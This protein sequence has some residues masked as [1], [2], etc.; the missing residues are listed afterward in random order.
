MMIRMRRTQQ[1]ATFPSHVQNGGRPKYFWNTKKSHFVTDQSQLFSSGRIFCDGN[2]WPP[3]RVHPLRPFISP[4]CIRPPSFRQHF[5]H[6]SI[7][8]PSSSDTDA[9]K[10]YITVIRATWKP[11]TELFIK[12]TFFRQSINGYV[13]R[14]PN[15]KIW[16]T[17]SSPVFRG[18]RS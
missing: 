4:L 6:S 17:V 9:L 18:V 11:I 7:R 1:Y 8:H 15:V 14:T 5:H 3:R 10:C 16:F 13:P 2:F 12:P